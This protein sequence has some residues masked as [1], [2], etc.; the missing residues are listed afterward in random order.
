MDEFTLASD[1]GV[2][3]FCRRWLPTGKPRAAVVVVHGA[4]EHSGRYARVAELLQGEGYA[5]Y[6]LDL[7]GH[8]HTSGTTGPGRSVR[9]AWTECSP[10]SMRSFGVLAPRSGMLPSSCSDT[11]WARSSC[12][13]SWWEPR[14][15]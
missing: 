10:T 5:V 11:R 2:D 14:T 8:G 6:T 3:V 13:P 9:A 15:T 7:R 12:R 1:D 4:A